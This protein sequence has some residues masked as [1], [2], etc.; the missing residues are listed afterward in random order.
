V[1]VYIYKYIH[2][3]Y[4]DLQQRNEVF[5]K[6]LED[7]ESSIEKRNEGDYISMYVFMH[8]YIYIYIYIHVPR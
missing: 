4:L 8:I 6:R 3:I 7:L 1:D 5:M 2:N